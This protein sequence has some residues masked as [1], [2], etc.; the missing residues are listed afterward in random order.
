M[1]SE[2]PQSTKSF[3]RAMTNFAQMMQKAQKFKQKMQE[4]QDRAQQMEV[5]GEAGQ[6]LVTCRMTGKHE[7]KGLKVD[8]SLIKPGEADVMEDLIVAAVNDAR[9]RAEK[10]MTD[11][12][13]KLMKEM[14]LPPGM[15]LPF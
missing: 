10:V 2:K 9:A 3:A 12:T 5:Q 15:D 6:G 1:Q 13:G 11:E 7:L 14:G 8:P 4:L